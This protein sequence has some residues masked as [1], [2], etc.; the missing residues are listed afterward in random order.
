MKKQSFNQDRKFGVEIEFHSVPQRAV[1]EALVEKGLLAVVEGYNHETRGYWKVIT[2]SSCGYEL[3]SP[4]LKGREGLRQLELALEALNELGAKV[5]KKCG[6]HVHH[7]INEY[8]AKQIANIYASY[9]KYES[10]IDTF[11]P[12]SRRANENHFCQTLSLYTSK[13][14][15]LDRLKDVKELSDL[16]RIYSSRYVKLNCHSYIKYGTIEFRQHAGTISYEKVYN[17]ILLTQ[18][19]VENGKTNVQ[20]K[21]NPARDNFDAFRDTFGLVPTF[22]ADDEIFEMMKWFRNRAKALAV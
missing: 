4:P 9:I 21:Y 8:N 13:E 17:W 7:D 3:V 18:Q 15:M 5:D 16:T 14:A 20:K 19:I 2:D 12:K 10:V 1:A 11:M 22:G 6:L